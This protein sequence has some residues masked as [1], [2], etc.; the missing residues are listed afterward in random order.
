M[1]NEFPIF[2][3]F[4]ASNFA[5]F[6]T[7][8]KN[9][10]MKFCPDFATN[11][12]KEWRVS[13]F[14]SN[15]RK[16]IRKLQKILKSDSVKIIHYYSFVSLDLS[17]RLWRICSSLSLALMWRHLYSL[18]PPALF[19]SQLFRISITLFHHGFAILHVTW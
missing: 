3:S 13:L 6:C 15:L 4:S 5:I 1:K 19:V 7:N 18:N 2:R 16:Q 17:Q 10:V 12:R 11:S 8:F 9:I 14:Q